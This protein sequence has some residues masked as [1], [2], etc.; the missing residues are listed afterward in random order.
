[1][2]G[3]LLG[4]GRLPIQLPEVLSLFHTR[5]FYTPRRGCS[6]E[7]VVAA[8]TRSRFQNLNNRR[9]ESYCAF[10]DKR[11]ESTAGWGSATATRR[12]QGT[13]RS[14][15]SPR[16]ICPHRI[17]REAT[18][19]S[20]F[21]LT[22]TPFICQQIRVCVSRTRV[23]RVDPLLPVDRDIVN[24]TEKSRT[25]RSQFTRSGNLCSDQFCGS[26]SIKTIMYFLQMG[27]SGLEMLEER[28]YA[29]DSRASES[30]PIKATADRKVRGIEAESR[31]IFRSGHL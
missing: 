21:F 14:T 13:S 19:W 26:L 23:S 9:P 2:L 30:D 6:V 11:S 27:L 5:C 4:G 31:S 3:T 20:A 16:D 7:V 18:F 8:N 28:N 10:R 15:V 25:I 22:R 1:M 17:P 29:Q 24:S 12:G